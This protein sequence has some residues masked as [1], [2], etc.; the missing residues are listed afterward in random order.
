M[1]PNL[2]GIVINLDKPIICQMFTLGF[3]KQEIKCIDYSYFPS[4]L[5]I[6]K[7]E[8]QY[9]SNKFF[10]NKTTKINNFCLINLDLNKEKLFQSIS[11][12]GIE[13]AQISKIYHSGGKVA[14]I[15]R[16]DLLCICYN[17]WDPKNEIRKWPLSI[18]WCRLRTPIPLSIWF[19]QLFNYFTTVLWC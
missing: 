6:R 17:I 2:Y 5:K 7:S 18:Y 3:W 8:N 12:Y 9:L 15:C 16:L 10:L 4:G 1:T 13:V 14:V 19:I 11:H